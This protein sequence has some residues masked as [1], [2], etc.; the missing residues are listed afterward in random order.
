MTKG[1]INLK[2]IFKE[3]KKACPFVETLIPKKDQDD[4]EDN[5]DNE[6]N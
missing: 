1:L 3:S 4:D 6:D 5:E 2:K